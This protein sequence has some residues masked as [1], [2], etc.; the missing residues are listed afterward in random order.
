MQHQFASDN[1]AGA[2]PAVLQAIAE[3]NNGHAAS[4]GDDEWTARAVARFREQ[5]GNVEVSFVFNGTGANVVALAQMLRPHEA[6]ICPE[7]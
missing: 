4:Y 1:Y 5:L 3:A 2:H 7:S 6:V